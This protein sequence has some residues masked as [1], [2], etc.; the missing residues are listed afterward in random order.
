[1]SRR[2]PA[3]LWSQAES[4]LTTDEKNMIANV[5]DTEID[6]LRPGWFADAYNTDRAMVRALCMYAL[7]G[8]NFEF[9]Y[10]MSFMELVRQ[11]DNFKKG[12]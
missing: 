11:W 7:L 9:Y 12:N 3:W 6:K 2:P 5:F 8:V 1:M 4:P 10:E